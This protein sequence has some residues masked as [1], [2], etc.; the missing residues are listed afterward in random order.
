MDDTADFMAPGASKKLKRPRVPKAKKAKTTTNGS[1]AT[2][3]KA[4]KSK[5]AGGG[6]KRQAGA[7][8]A[9]P[10]V[11]A[12]KEELEISDDVPLFS[13]CDGSPFVASRTR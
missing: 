8:K 1:A 13:E 3:T 2:R 9:A 12:S 11:A 5:A 10:R 7:A 6:G 4:T